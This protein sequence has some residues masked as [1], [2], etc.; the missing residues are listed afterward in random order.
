M[1]LSNLYED[2][3]GKYKDLKDALIADISGF[4]TPLREKRE[5]I[6][7]D[8]DAVREIL[9]KGGEKARARAKLQIAKVRAAVGLVY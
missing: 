4:I 7:A 3:K 6:A 9:R 5:H 2:K 1:G 8:K